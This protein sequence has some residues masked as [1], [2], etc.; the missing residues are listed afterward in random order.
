MCTLLALISHKE[1]A[2]GGR[3]SKDVVTGCVVALAFGSRQMA[4]F[5]AS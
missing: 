5:T 1:I 4:A 3:E 2:K